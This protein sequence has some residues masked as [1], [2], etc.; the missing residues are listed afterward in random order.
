ME[1]PPKALW[2]KHSEPS[3]LTQALN[4]RPINESVVSHSILTILTTPNE[5][6]LQSTRPLREGKDSHTER[7]DGQE[8]GFGK[9][10]FVG[11]IE[12]LSSPT[13]KPRASFINR[14]LEIH[15]FQFSE[16]EGSPKYFAWEGANY[17]RKVKPIH[18]GVLSFTNEQRRKTRPM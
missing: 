11:P 5:G 6:A 3:K 14:R 9:S 1:H 15:I 4:D 16:V 18:Y 2:I 13:F 10:N 12:Q 8:H 7:P 17:G